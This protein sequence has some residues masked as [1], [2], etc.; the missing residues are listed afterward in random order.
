[1]PEEKRA[2][3]QPHNVILEDRKRLRLTGVSDVDSFNE[4]VISVY[5][6]MGVL[7]VRGEG[8]HIGRLSVETGE[9]D[10]TGDIYGM[11]YTDE[12]GRNKGSFFKRLTK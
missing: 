7:T 12:G 10:L 11:V 3:A 5:T 2:P 8:L 4:Q 9:L 6:E 1:M